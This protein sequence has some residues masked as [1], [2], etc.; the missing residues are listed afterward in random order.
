MNEFATR[1]TGSSDL[2]K[3]NGRRPHASINFV[4]AH[5]GFCLRDLVTY[6]EKRNLA[7]LEDNR[8]GDSHNNGWN[9]GV[10]G[11][12]TDPAINELRLRQRKN[13]FATPVVVSGCPHDSRGR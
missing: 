5:D 6:H 9:C 1:L 10:E 8:D 13:L 4:T 12:T 2:Y 7:N 3:H 11:E